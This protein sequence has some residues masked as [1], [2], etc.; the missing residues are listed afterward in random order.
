MVDINIL[1]KRVFGNR[2]TRDLI[3]YYVKHSRRY[4]NC[5]I[6]WFVKHKLWQMLKDKMEAKEPLLLKH[7]NCLFEIPDYPLFKQL[8]IQY[9]DYFPLAHPKL[10]HLGA[11]NNNMEILKFLVEKGYKGYTKKA[12][13]AAWSSKNYE[14]V[15]YLV[16]YIP[17]MHKRKLVLTNLNKSIL[18]RDIELVKCFVQPKFIVTHLSVEEKS[19]ITSTAFS[20]GD[21]EMFKLIYQYYPYKPCIEWFKETPKCKNMT[22]IVKYVIEAF[23]GK[24]KTEFLE[25]FA[26]ATDDHCNFELLIYMVDAKLIDHTYLLEPIFSEAAFRKQELKYYDILK[27]EAT[28]NLKTLTVSRVH[29]SMVSVKSLEEFLDLGLKVTPS[30]LRMAVRNHRERKTL[31]WDLF[32]ALWQDLH[33]SLKEQKTMKSLFDISCE[34]GNSKLL[35]FL[36]DQIPD[37]NTRPKIVFNCWVELTKSDA[38]LPFIKILLA[39]FACENSDEIIRAIYEAIRFGSI[40]IVT[41]L[42]TKLSSST[43]RNVDDMSETYKLAAYH[44][45]YDILKFLIGQKLPFKN[46]ILGKSANVAIAALLL[47]NGHLYSPTLTYVD[48]VSRDISLLTFLFEYKKG[49]QAINPQA[50]KEAIAQSKFL[51][52]KYLMDNKVEWSFHTISPE[53]LEAI[54]KSGNIEM[55]QYLHHKN[56]GQPEDYGNYCFGPAMEYGRL[57]L[58]KHLIEKFDPTMSNF[59][60]TTNFKFLILKKYSWVLEYFKPE[61]MNK[62]SK[63]SKII[64]G[65]FLKKV[66]PEK[67]EDDDTSFDKYYNNFTNDVK[68][69]LFGFKLFK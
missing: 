11:V 47:E 42:F 29:G 51:H 44:S 66:K 61:I 3:S 41:F 21:V 62:N 49:K 9:H 54:G 31:W 19:F 12:F 26:N 17:W 36:I 1:F 69:P 23:P 15:R 6:D 25:T 8:F 58:I 64:T 16:E 39:N 20:T 4:S 22:E 30:C 43:L 40:D 46:D 35:Q 60:N 52:F 7:K 32:Y 27:D 34:E 33:P 10:F 53:I 45:R 55:F 67:D 24:I 5:T 13:Q 38:N 68:K 59:V 56:P 65:D 18:S 63:L 14:M 37:T 2:I 48:A 50:I 57:S 28:T